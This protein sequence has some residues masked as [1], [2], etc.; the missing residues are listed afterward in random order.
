MSNDKN[1]NT[2][3]G[4]F[5]IA[6]AGL[7]LSGSAFAMQPLAQGYMAAAGHATAEGKCG[8]GECG[9]AR[10]GTSAPS[11]NKAAEGK[12]GEG[13]CGD[14]HFAQVDTD[15]DGRVSRAEFLAASP[16]RIAEFPKKDANGDGFIAKQESFES[17]KAVYE[18]NGKAMP[19][20]R[21][22]QLQDK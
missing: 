13:K 16:E 18:A 12:C 3:M 5:A 14:D 22:K 11:A 7:V 17:I 21:F 20:G 19:A 8:E 15:R 4:A 1:R 10:A 2:P 9:G 6:L